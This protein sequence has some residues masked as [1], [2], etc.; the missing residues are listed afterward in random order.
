[1]YYLD[2]KRGLAW[3]EELLTDDEHS[4]ELRQFWHQQLG[5]LQPLELLTDFPRPTIQ[6]Y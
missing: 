6:Q 1:M 5:G 4:T 3:Q 2:G